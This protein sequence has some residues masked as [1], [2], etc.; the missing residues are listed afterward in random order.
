MTLV[1]YINSLIAEG[2]DP[3]SVEADIYEQFGKTVA[4]VFADSTGFTRISQKYGILHFLSRMIQVREC[5][6]PVLEAHGCIMHHFE[7]D[8]IVAAFQNVDD[9]VRA[10][11]A[12]HEAL[13]ASK[14][15]LSD[16]EP[17][18]MCIG[19]GYGRVLD[20]GEDEGFFGEQVNLASKLGEDIAS[21]GETLITPDAYRHASGELVGGGELLSMEISGMRVEYYRITEGRS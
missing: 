12:M 2:R 3:V 15:M 8:N 21:A 19:I 4:M 17:Y 20:A 18:Q 10:V 5:L 7:A 6:G 14:I 13:R 9:A 16:D 11:A 1:E